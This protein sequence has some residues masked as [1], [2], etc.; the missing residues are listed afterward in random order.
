MR[1]HLAE[2]LQMVADSVR[3]GHTLEE[4]ADLVARELKGPLGAEFGQC[5]QQLKLGQSPL[6]VLT[7]MARR[8]PLSEFRVFA[9]A[10]L[11]HTRTGGNLAQLTERMAAAS[12]ARQEFY[13]HVNAATAG[14]RLSA[15]GMVAGAILAVIALTWIEPD[16][17]GKFIHTDI[18]PYLAGVAATLQL[19]GAVWVWQILKVNF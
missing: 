11:V 8:I 12:R 6:A 4:A 17:M 3:A 5:T 14:S 18:G 19:A 1:V 7:R 15:I 9:T 13:G 10:V 2:S 16:Y